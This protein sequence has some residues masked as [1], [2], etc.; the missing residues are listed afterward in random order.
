[1]NVTTD[2][3]LISLVTNASV[4]VQLVLLLLLIIS[5]MS[6]SYIFM[7]LLTIRR[8]RLETARFEDS[9]WGG[10][11]LNTLYERSS[12]NAVQAGALERIFHAGFREFQRH[13]KNGTEDVTA[14][15][16]GVQRAMKATYQREMDTLEAHLA[17]LATVGSVS[18]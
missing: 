14:V 17:F 15:T 13:L 8:A 4:L 11:D 12:A 5:L 9:F 2:I 10:A 6:W 3:T 18:P 16:N 1:M 7:K